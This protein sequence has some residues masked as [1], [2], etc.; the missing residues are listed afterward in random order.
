[1]NASTSKLSTKYSWSLLIFTVFT[2]G[3]L[4]Y[5]F[6]KK[7]IDTNIGNAF[8]LEGYFPLLKRQANP[9]N[10]ASS[11]NNLL[12]NFQVS[13]PP[14]VPKGGRLCRLNYLQHIFGN[15]FGQPAKGQYRPPSDCGPPGSWA[16]V[17][18]ELTVTSKGTQFDR[19]S[20][21]F[22][23]NIESTKICFRLKM[24]RSN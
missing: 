8:N 6:S 19:L 4:S 2:C 14:V 20:S 15:S 23:N 13:Q 9:E 16:S 12:L 7:K 17:V 10:Q 24:F 18:L 1:M 5:S 3:F 22:L 11:S 21:I